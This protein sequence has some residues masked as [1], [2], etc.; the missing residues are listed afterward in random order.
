MPRHLLEI[1][2]LTRSDVDQLFA[3]ADADRR[4]ECLSGST[5]LASFFQESTRTRLGFMA[6][7]ARQGA[8][9]L[10]MGH[11]KRLRQEPFADQQMVLAE[12]ADILVVR[13]WD[14]AFAHDLAA[15]ERCAVV[16][17]GRSRIDLVV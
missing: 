2:D 8:A 10:D 13:H 15:I 17:A 11:A 3:A 6:A 7:A 4:R 5:M 1:A 12:A 16:N 9:V 14:S